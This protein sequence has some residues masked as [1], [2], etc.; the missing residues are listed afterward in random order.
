MSDI[1]FD[2]D[3]DED[4]DSE[5]ELETPTDL[6]ETEEE[7]E[8]RS[9]NHGPGKRGKRE[10]HPVPSGW[11]TPADMAIYLNYHRPF[12]EDVEFTAGQLYAM[13]NDEEFP[14][15]LHTDGRTILDEAAVIQYLDSRK[16]RM[17]AERA[18]KAEAKLNAQT[19]AVRRV[20]K[21]ALGFARVAR[22]LAA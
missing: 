21:A 5:P 22:D 10:K 3:T 14:C 12:G 17:A 20:C 19:A 8:A 18:K 9:R 11:L 6:S 16:E 2:F 1:D 4:T 15:K 7:A 13:R